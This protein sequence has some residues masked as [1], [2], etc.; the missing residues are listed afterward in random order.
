[1][2]TQNGATFI[3]R[4]MR[5]IAWAVV[6]L[7]ML[8]I[9]ASVAKAQ[10]RFELEVQ[11]HET[12]GRLI[13]NFPDRMALPGYQVSSENG[14]LAITFDEAL[15]GILP[16]VPLALGNYVSVA[17][18]DPG[19]TGIRMGLRGPIQV[20][21]IEA[22]EALYI[23]LLPPN[24]VGLPP[25]LPPEVIARLSERAE[26]A[27]RLAEE[28][29]RAELVQEFNP[30]A[31]V[32]V[33]R[34]PTFA[35][36]IFDWNVGSQAEFV[37]NGTEASIK[38]EWPVPI[39]LSA[40]WSD[41]PAEIVSVENSVNPSGSFINLEL[42]PDV[43]ARFYEE[44]PAQFILDIDVPNAAQTVVDARD[45]ARNTPIS[46][47]RSDALVIPA[48]LDGNRSSAVDL[49]PQAAV[50][51]YVDV[52]GT[53]VRVVFPF[54]R[55]TASA[56]FR[57]GNVVW[58]LFDTN[59]QVQTPGQDP[60]Y[61]SLIADFAVHQSGGA[62]VI[63]MEMTEDRL[64]TIGSEGRAWVLSLGDV[65]LNA[66]VPIALERR[67]NQTGLFEM[68][69]DLERP[70]RV[71]HLRDPDV[72][73]ILEVVTAYPPARGIVRDFRYVDF[74][75]P[76]SAHG[77]VIRPNHDEIE[78]S[79]D[80]NLAVISAKEGLTLSAVQASQFRLPEEP[81]NTTMDL[82]NAYV[83]QPEQFAPRR[84]EIL[85]RVTVAQGRE[86]DRAR[87]QLAEFYI[88]NNLAHEALGI[89]RV[90]GDEQRPVD[91]PEA[92]LIAQGAAN[93]LAGRS[94]EAIAALTSNSVRFEPDAMLWRAIARSE[95]GDYEAA[96]M[97]AI[98]AEPIVKSYPN[99][100][101][102]RFALAGA[103]AAIMAED[104]STASRFLAGATLP[105]LTRDQAAQYQLLTGMLDELQGRDL[106]AIESYGRVITADRRPTTTQ[107]VLRT[108]SVLDRMERLDVARAVDTL[109]V[110]AAIWRG[111]RT[112]LAVLELLTR[113]QYRNGDYRDAFQITRDAA[114]RHP[115]SPVLS[116]M[117]DKARTEFASLYLDGAA[118]GMD[119]VE[120][121][122]IYYDYRHLTPPGSQGDLMIRNLAGRLIKVDLLHQAAELLEYQIDNR[123][124]GAARAQVAAD[125]AVV[126]VANRAPQK[127]L[128][129]LYRSRIA[130]L[131]P[132]LERQRRVLEARA[133]V[134][135]RRH[136]LALD[137]LQSVE[138]RDAD[139]LRIDAYW[140]GQ[141]YQQA[142]E[143]IE[144]VY[145]DDLRR[146]ALSP[147]ARGNLIKAAVGYVMAGDMIGLSRLNGRYADALSTTPEWPL[148]AYVSESVEITEREFREIARQIAST[149]SLNAFL[150]AY[151]D[152]YTAENAITP[153][154]AARVAEAS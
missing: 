1:M 46:S 12:F 11:N 150:N 94:Q 33:G 48:A 62:Q 25:S 145:L 126:H 27:A 104:V 118:D 50:Q 60:V 40:V 90:M 2:M 58:M 100:V 21:T 83:T 4:P 101:G 128:D 3:S 73:D 97:D 123:L 109:S 86:L 6:M 75:A 7:F 105:Q 87:Q 63:R 51:P 10:E 154:R 56:V 78:V 30:I 147:V 141:R 54:T 142:A 137:I 144:R 129:A 24:W 88:A 120:A 23:D 66:T 98:G 71:H 59:A 22:G 108:M 69:A 37:Q 19:A 81:Q 143:L 53:S 139:M 68:T 57:R 133:L 96:R 82:L 130:N 136:D 103:R 36:V 77:L 29:R 95:M 76:R 131:P 117:L 146:G 138:G 135:A 85:A 28:R 112:E 127:A 39:D 17:R 110:Q 124:Q 91:R 106:D 107:A 119:A 9:S 65:L 32:R 93:A 102:A 149:D 61:D 72:G 41:M 113:L 153:M 125:L 89:L 122:G 80:R 132:A 31:K 114:A 70:S 20:N 134:D 26:E 34:H 116:T 99:W 13:V 67:Q 151:R 92:E 16:D 52:I 79:I 15:R 152:L 74:T 111:D 18:I 45:L 49:E 47:N 55:D 121:L 35:R 84:D 44:S 64:A 5:C 43:V 148:F 42:A 14:V 115:D 140:N 8:L 38:F